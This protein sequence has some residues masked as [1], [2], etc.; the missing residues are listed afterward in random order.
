VALALADGRRIGWE[1]PGREP[2][3]GQILPLM[4]VVSGGQGGGWPHGL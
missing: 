4:P 3:P 1:G 2:A